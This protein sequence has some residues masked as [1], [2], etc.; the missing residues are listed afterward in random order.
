MHKF[1]TKPTFAL[2]FCVF[3]LSVQAQEG[4]KLKREPTLIL[5]PPSTKDEAPVYIEADR[6][7]GHSDKETRAEGNA[8]LRKRGQAV[9]GDELRYDKPSDE[10]TAVGN[11]RI[12]QGGDLLEGESLRYNLETSR[13][14]IAKPRYLLTPEASVPP[15]T[16]GKPR[17]TDLD[18]RGRAE[19]LLFEG[20]QHYRAEQAE[21]TTCK[22]GNDSWFLRAADLRIDKDRDVGVARDASIVF[23]GQP[24]LYSPYI[25]FSLH[26]QRKTGFLTPHYGNSSTSGFEFTLPYYW[27]IAPNLD[28]TIA[29]RALSKRGVQLNTEF[30]YL[31]PRYGGEAHLEFLPSDSVTG[32]DRYLYFLKHTQSFANGWSSAVNLQRVSDDK[33]FTDLSTLV[34]LTSQA[35]LS[36]D[37]TIGRGGTWGKSGTWSF[38]GFVQRW[39]TLQTDPLAP[40]APPYDRLPQ[41]TLTAQ[42]QNVLHGD[43]D[44]T[45]SFVDFHHPTQVTGKRFVAYPSLSVPLQTS[46]A[47]VNPK[48]GL[49]VTHY[50]L[51]KDTTT[52]PDSTRTLPIFSAESGVLFDRDTSI[53][54]KR[55][56]QTLE[57]KLYYVYIPYRDQSQMPNFES[58]VQDVNF[59]TLFAEN[60]FSGQDRINDANQLTVGI[61]SRFVNRENGVEALRGGI[62]QRFYFQSQRVTVPGVQ[63]RSSQSSTS[64]LLT[65]VS[66]TIFPHWT[67]DVGW[68]YNTDVNQ[69]Q[70]LNG[71]VRYQPRP[72]KVLN[73]SY[74]ETINS[75]R[76]TDISAEWPLT[77]KWTA[78]GRW[79]YSLLDSRT[80]E[81][82]AGFEYNGGCWVFRVVGH[83][84]ATA[85]QAA[86]TSFFV[87]L[88][89]NGV[90]KIGSN[91]LD[92]LQ[93]SIL[94][95]VPTGAAGTPR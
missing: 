24:I 28:A 6:I 64:D 49:H 15:P 82:L 52:L 2:I 11:V 91:P 63:P 8:R 9:S 83:R 33:Y 47:Y 55:Y 37:L 53:F 40:L 39:Q 68:Q 62:A 19:R 60:Q 61:S 4:L 71:S 93:R 34:T 51:D 79:N 42:N 12:E 23:L 59:A 89:L 14:F 57:P 75:V 27:N 21:Y 1:L 58:G 26:Q 25:S 50:A 48:I 88:E 3:A 70:R 54:G 67:A 29:P 5:V 66:G 76:Q 17:F 41:L 38:S 84:L 18:A 92:L 43:F 22:P 7:T 94:G 78:V 85:T 73:A 36:N 20:P 74:R 87:Q 56:T 80:L 31:E 86:S 30:R 69:T 90:S 81:A 10:V 72:G 44:F 77:G 16:N 46:Y 65:A 35:V 95:Y 45:G 32:A 13:G